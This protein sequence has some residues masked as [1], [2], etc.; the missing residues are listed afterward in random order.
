MSD[1]VPEA[2][3]AP[4]ATGHPEP[5]QRDGLDITLTSTTEE[6]MMVA[7]LECL[8]LNLACSSD[9]LGLDEEGSWV[10]QLHTL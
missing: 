2:T 4:A 6:L 8:P 5:T 1:P 7:H 10:D 9:G 3:E